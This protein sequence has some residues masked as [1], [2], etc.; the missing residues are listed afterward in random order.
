MTVPA[1]MTALL[2]VNEG[3]AKTPEAGLAAME[4]YV[5]YGKVP[6]PTPKSGQVLVNVALASVNPSDLAFIKGAYGQPC[7]KGM[8]AGFEGVGE[9]VA[10]GGGSLG[11]S[12]T[13][14]RVAMVTG[15]TGSGTWADYAVADASTCIPL[16]DGVRDEDG[17][18]MIVNPLTAMAMLDIVKAEDSKAFVVTAGASQLCKLMM[19][20]ARD[21]G[22]RAIAIVRRDNQIGLLKEAGAFHVLNSESL[23]YKT[24]LAG[25]IK[26]EKPRVFLD[27]VTGPLASE[28]FYRMGRGARWI[29]YGRLDMTLPVIREPGQLIFMSKKIEGFWLTQWMIDTP[30]AQKLT[31]IRAVQERFASGDWNTDVTATIP[32]DEVMKRLPEELA[33]PNGKVFILPG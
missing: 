20:L 18:A 6:V 21:A 19:G 33:K 30:V 15:R 23:N 29:I 10:S 11:D 31:T 4:P 7:V 8:P 28:I 3:Y 5:E 2:Q 12:L 14:K 17:A 26:Q 22:Y 16:M 25:V 9:V 24:D 32:L 1:E 27:A 13:G